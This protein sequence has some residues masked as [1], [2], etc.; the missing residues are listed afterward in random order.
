MRAAL[1]LLPGLGLAQEGPAVGV[2]DDS[3]AGALLGYTSAVQLRLERDPV[4]AATY[5]AFWHQLAGESDPATLSDEA[6]RELLARS[7]SV[8]RALRRRYPQSPAPYRLAD[9]L[10]VAVAALAAA[11]GSGQPESLL[12]S[13]DR[14]V[15]PRLTVNGRYEFAGTL[16]GPADLGIGADLWLRCRQSPAC[17]EAHDSLFG[18]ALGGVPLTAG[19]AERLER[20][21]LLRDLPEMPRLAAGIAGLDQRLRNS[22][23]NLRDAAAVAAGGY[24]QAIGGGLTPSAGVVDPAELGAL[25]ALGRA[26]AWLA[27]SEQLANSFVVAGPPLLDYS[28]LALKGGGGFLAATA[29]VGLLFAGV[30]ALS[31]FDGGAAPPPRELNRLIGELHESTYRNFVGLRAES[32]LASN[33]IDARLVRLG[34]T[35]DVVRDDVARIETAQRARIRADF[36]VQDARRWTAFEEDNDRCFSLRSLDART[37]RLRPADFRRCEDRFL[38]GAVRRAQYLTRAQDYLLDARFLEPADLRF[39]FHHHYPLLLTEAGMDSKTAL[40][41][42]DPFEWQQHAAALLRLYQENPAAPGDPARR[43][44]SLRAL[45][46]PGARIQQALAG[47]AL[48]GNSRA[49]AFRSA[50][51]QQSLDAYFAALRGL[52]NR[53]AALDDPE[54]DRY[55]KRL[56]EGL[57]QP[58]PAGRR[59]AA[60]EAVLS[61]AQQG[62]T[63]LR[64]C[65]DATDAQFLAPESGL[66]AES[67]RFFDAPITATELARSWNRDAVAGFGFTL[68]G[69]AALVPRPYLWAALDGHGELEICLAK[70]RP[71]VAEFTREEGPLRNH[72]K[73]NVALEAQLVVRFTPGAVLTRELGLPAARPAIEIARYEATR[74]CSFA[75]RNDAE[76]CSRGQCLAQLAPQL[77]ASEAGAPINGGSCSGEPLPRQLARQN[78]LEGAGELVDLAEALAGPYWQ[79]RAERSARLLADA[80]RSSEYE[81]ASALYLQYFALA[82]TTLGTWPDPSEPL[83]PLY[84]DEDALTPRAVLE[85]L[86]EARSGAAALE[87]EL[88]AVRSQVLA[89]VVARGRE[90]ERDDALYRLRHLHALRETLTRIDLMLAAYQPST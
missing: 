17:I 21:E 62:N 5:L 64:A 69:W 60:I 34:L 55:G 84:A 49:P 42:V 12:A 90:V 58:L 71:A 56:T 18:E 1:L 78:R 48:A 15:A 88:A 35:L 47:L 59:L 3:I 41:L 16:Q 67:R 10:N 20:D 24:W 27:G 19:L 80:A 70:M 66:S 53:V 13:V 51:H 82:G 73:A 50:L 83:A 31:L 33:A 44:E 43:A 39:P 30:Q 86:V 6:A 36:L 81:N 65:T 76:G 75:Y 26:S 14:L 7:E 4:L 2:P 38:Q 63:A 29:G 28:R 68:E 46:A 54:A 79:A 72:L 52:A 32:M 74:A 40:A 87:A 45:R 11:G 23:L 77:W 9:T 8:D 89:Q 85:R 57:D 25:L 22:P 61:G 37:G